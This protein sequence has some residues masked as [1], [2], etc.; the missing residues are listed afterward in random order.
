MPETF[1]ARTQNMAIATKFQREVLRLK[2]H[3]AHMD[4][5]V[6]TEKNSNVVIKF[7]G[8]ETS[9]RNPLK[10]YGNSQYSYS[11]CAFYYIFCGWGLALIWGLGAGAYLG[12]GSWRLFET[13]R[14]L[15]F[16]LLGWV[17]IRGGRLFEVGCLKTIFW[18]WVLVRG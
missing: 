4:I 12:G 3:C 7:S 16:E 18:G 6:E 15:I 17:L 2:Q 14:F 1:K 8:N 5:S 13:G 11:S 10:K 9:Y